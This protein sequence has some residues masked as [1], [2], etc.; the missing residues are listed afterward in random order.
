MPSPPAGFFI[1]SCQPASIIPGVNA[2]AQ[3]GMAAADTVAAI[4]CRLS[5]SAERSVFLTLR[6]GAAR[7]ADLGEH[8]RVVTKCLVHVRD[9]LHD[10]AEER[11]LAVIHHL[12]DEIRA[13]RLAIGV[14][15]DL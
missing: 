8:R 5:R 15:L 13:D 6:N 9:H 4:P 7:Q 12:G 11:A 2:R 10:L 1:F 14:E 3:K